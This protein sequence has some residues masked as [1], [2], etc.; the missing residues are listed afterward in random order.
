MRLLLP[1]CLQT[2]T[3]NK[4]ENTEFSQNDFNIAV[5]PRDNW[6]RN[7]FLVDNKF[8]YWIKFIVKGNLLVWH[9]YYCFSHPL[10]EMIAL[11]WM[12]QNLM[13]MDHIPRN[14]Q[15]HNGYYWI[16][17]GYVS[18]SGESS[19]RSPAPCFWHEQ[20]RNDVSSPWLR[21]TRGPAAGDKNSALNFLLCKLENRLVRAL[22]RNTN[23]LHSSTFSAHA[24]VLVNHLLSCVHRH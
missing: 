10:F 19:S 4:G 20:W 7:I 15:N 12:N 17:Q 6:G 8:L 2:L 21:W 1:G 16:R 9:C 22:P 18:Y 14:P 11:N 5:L 3:G 13:I 23:I 24:W